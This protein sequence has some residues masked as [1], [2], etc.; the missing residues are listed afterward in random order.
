MPRGRARASVEAAMASAAEMERFFDAEETGAEALRALER[1]PSCELCEGVLRDPTT[2]PCAH[3]FCAEC[4]RDRLE[5][6][7]VYANECPRCT[8]PVYVKDLRPNRT[9]AGVISRI[10]LL[11][12]SPSPRDA[13][14]SRMPSSA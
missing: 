10:C 8:H 4:V 13:T 6:V 3:T 7:G 5:G 11:Y 14:L 2:L 9:V 1:V 12:T